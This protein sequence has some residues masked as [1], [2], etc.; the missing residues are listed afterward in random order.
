MNLQ[1]AR[2]DLQDVRMQMRAGNLK[3][4][5]SRV[6]HT[7]NMTQQGKRWCF[8]LNNYTTQEYESIRGLCTTG[9]ISYMVLGKEQGRHQETPHIQGFIIFT[10]R[11]R[12]HKVRKK[13]GT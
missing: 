8:T 2:L 3:Y 6:K 11:E 12:F 10:K 5:R 1:D 7:L 13:R 4:I 9:T